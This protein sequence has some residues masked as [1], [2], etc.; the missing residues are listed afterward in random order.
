ML[1]KAHEYCR[2]RG[3]EARIELDLPHAKTGSSE[4]GISRRPSG[5]L[6]FR[7][8]DGPVPH[9]TAP[10]TP[11]P[12]AATDPLRELDRLEQWILRMCRLRAKRS[13]EP[14]EKCSDE[15]LAAYRAAP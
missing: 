14:F 4:R 9:P 7:C 10:S 2:A 6:A 1:T 3:Q 8:V 12:I 11:A 5:Q 15:N 13:S